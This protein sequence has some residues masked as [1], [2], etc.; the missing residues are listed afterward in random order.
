MQ[1]CSDA[2]ACLHMG[3]AALCHDRTKPCIQPKCYNQ[4]MCRYAHSL[5]ALLWATRLHLVVKLGLW[6]AVELMWNTFPST[7]TSSLSLTGCHAGLLL[8]LWLQP[9]PPRPVGKVQ[10]G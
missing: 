2:G 10:Q 5:P 1:T 4:C 8:A 6:L 3:R 9:R 7:A